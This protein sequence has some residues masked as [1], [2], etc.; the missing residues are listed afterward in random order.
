MLRP[1]ATRTGGREKPPGSCRPGA[2]WVAISCCSAALGY[3]D[4][5]TCLNDPSRHIHPLT[6]QEIQLA[7][8]AP[9]PM[10][11]EDPLLAIGMHHDLDRARA[12]RVEVVGGVSLPIEILAH[13]HRQ[14]GPEGR[15][16]GK[17]GG[18]EGGKRDGVVSHGQRVVHGCNLLVA[19]S[20]SLTDRRH[21]PHQRHASGKNHARFCIVTHDRVRCQ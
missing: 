5:L 18:I 16:Y 10:A 12:D 4:D 9:R 3:S 2:A 6:G 11:G 7:E 19:R 17:V 15:E 8:E 14:A 21:G 13:A 20:G 1:S